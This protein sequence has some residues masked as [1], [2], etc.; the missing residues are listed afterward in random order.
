M[1]EEK[2]NFFGKRAG[3]YQE[4]GRKLNTIE[5]SFTLDTDF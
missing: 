1:M 2:T 3:H 5:N 4:T